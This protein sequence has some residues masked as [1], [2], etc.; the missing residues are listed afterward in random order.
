MANLQLHLQFSGCRPLHLPVEI[1]AHIIQYLDSGRDLAVLART[2]HLIQSE[3]ERALY[4]ELDVTLGSTFAEH[5]RTMPLRLT[6]HVHILHI[7]LGCFDNEMEHSRCDDQIRCGLM[8]LR[9]LKILDGFHPIYMTTDHGSRYPFH[10][11]KFTT[12]SPILDNIR[13]FFNSQSSIEILEWSPFGADLRTANTFDDDVLPNLRSFQSS[14]PTTAPLLIVTSAQRRVVRLAIESGSINRVLSL[15]TFHYP[16][17]RVLKVGGLISVVTHRL[18]S[19]F[20]NLSYLEFRVNTFKV[21]RRQAVSVS[22]TDLESSHPL[23][24]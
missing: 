11:V 21:S 4:R 14:V 7:M 9:N 8:R 13:S 12:G 16:P 24:R 20:P 2:C 23:L 22:Y 1:W 15:P 10:L 5:L 19:M 17:L 18:G 3:A 6:D